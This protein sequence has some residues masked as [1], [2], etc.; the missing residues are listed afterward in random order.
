MDA[1]ALELIVVDA[2]GCIVHGALLCH[3][4]Y[5]MKRTN[6]VRTCVNPYHTRYTSSLDYQVYQYCSYWCSIECFRTFVKS[7]R[8]P[9]LHTLVLIVNELRK[10]TA[11]VDALSTV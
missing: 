7:N 10:T 8:P 3:S 6:N 11:A 5:A 4:C 9:F 1:L 2:C